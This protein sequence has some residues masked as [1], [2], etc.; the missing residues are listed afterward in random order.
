MDSILTA[1]AASFVDDTCIG[2]LVP[3]IVVELDCLNSLLVVRNTAQ[4]PLEHAVPAFVCEFRN[5]VTRHR[6]IPVQAMVVSLSAVR[7]AIELHERVDE[8]LSRN[9][10]LFFGTPLNE[11]AVKVGDFQWVHFPPGQSVAW[12]EATGACLTRT[13]HRVLLVVGASARPPDSAKDLI[14][15]RNP[16]EV[17][18][19]VIR[20]FFGT[21]VG[22]YLSS[23]T[24]GGVQARRTKWKFTKTRQSHRSTAIRAPETGR[25]LSSIRVR[26]TVGSH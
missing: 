10:K 22:W 1:T 8:G 3:E 20:P 16:W 25:S 24:C 15:V 4:R 12:P 7:P 2:F 23:L 6:V 13:D 17:R 9:L 11:Y 26:K 5:F 18:R 19:P 14:C 21:K